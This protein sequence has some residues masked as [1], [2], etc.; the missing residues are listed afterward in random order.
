MYRLWGW[1]FKF[2]ES[3]P[4]YILSSLPNTPRSVPSMDQH[5]Y[6]IHSGLGVKKGAVATTA[7]DTAVDWATPEKTAQRFLGQPGE[8]GH[9]RERGTD[10]WTH[11]SFRGPSLPPGQPGPGP[12]SVGLSPALT[13]Q[14]I[15]PHSFSHSRYR[16]A[17]SLPQGESRLMWGHRKSCPC[18]TEVGN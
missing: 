5:C 12:L 7:P 1:D 18:R 15:H 14:R 17:A 9:N 10:R 8:G 13:V 16:T 4:M 3:G 6:L 11:S 2:A